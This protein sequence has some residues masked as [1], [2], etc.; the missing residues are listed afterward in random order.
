MERKRMKKILP[1]ALALAV[2]VCWADIV[3]YNLRK[4]LYPSEMSMANPDFWKNINRYSATLD[5]SLIP[6][7]ISGPVDSLSGGEP[8]EISL[9]TPYK[10]GTTMIIHFMDSHDK[11]PPTLAIFA[12]KN[13]VERIKVLPGAGKMHREWRSK[14]QQSEVTVNIPRSAMSEEGAKL[15][16]RNVEGSWA[17]IDWVE[18]HPK[19]PKKWEIWLA[20]GGTVAL[21]IMYGW[22]LTVNGLWRRHAANAALMTVSIIITL[23]VIEFVVRTFFPQMDFEPNLRIVFEQD[24]DIGYKLK[25]N[26]KTMLG[27]D[28]NRFGLRDYDNYTEK[29][30]AD[31]FRILVLGDSQTF[32][33]TALKDAYV[34]VL[35]RGFAGS[36]RKVEVLN[37]GGNGYGTDDEYL[38]LKKYGLRFDPDLVLLG[39]FVGNDITDNHMQ[40]N[41][42]VLDG[43]LI[44]KKAAE[45]YT[46][47]EITWER[48]KREFLNRFHLY[49]FLRSRDYTAVYMKMT[50]VGSEIRQK[51][52][53]AK[54]GGCFRNDDFRPFRDPSRYDELITQSWKNTVE[55]LGKLGDITKENNIGFGI[56]IIPAQIQFDTPAA[57]AR[58]EE[59]K[60]DGFDWAYP[61]KAVA[62]LAAERGWKIVDPIKYMSEH[63][64]ND[65]R[66]YY[67]HDTHLNENGSRLMAD[68]IREWLIAEKM[69]P[70]D[71]IPAGG[72]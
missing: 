14:G 4:T 30:P 70:A 41:Y 40:N 54:E 45:K 9:E 48:K 23:A 42:T 16:I 6:A 66:M 1:M 63:N 17:A 26:I 53:E 62:D 46:P 33:S 32:S 65:E 2:I 56:V 3:Q 7:L 58:K 28:T 39:F 55:Y 34:K 72:R 5:K 47:K 20:W 64:K 68:A 15:A 69:V 12:G 25:P 11:N 57:L 50:D 49:R 52:N 71:A 10:N 29:K 18:L 38:Y 24:P 8:K 19:S 51:M 27:N 31:V 13:E 22:F 43:M 59:L 36:K 61:Q 35:E 67:C 60:N 37:A 21:I 44:T